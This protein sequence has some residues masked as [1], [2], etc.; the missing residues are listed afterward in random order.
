MTN[1]QHAEVEYETALINLKQ[2][3]DSRGLKVMLGPHA[4]NHDS[5]NP[6]RF[7]MPSA[8]DYGLYLKHFLE[9]VHTNSH[10]L[11][12]EANFA[13]NAKLLATAWEAAA[14]Y[15]ELKARDEE[16]KHHV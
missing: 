1:L 8:R 7:S 5:M 10:F 2:A 15:E 14:R 4:R 9:P 3:T 13:R 16:Q 6:L 11:D 12:N